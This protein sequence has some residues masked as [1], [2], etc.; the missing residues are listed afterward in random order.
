MRTRL[1]PTLVMVLVTCGLPGPAGR[2]PAAAQTVVRE[3]TPIA[4]DLYRVR[5]AGHYS[6]LLVTPAGI[7]LGD[8]INRDTATWLAAELRSR[9]NQ[10]VRYVIYS[11]DHAD[12]ASGG[13]VFSDTATFV[14]HA[15]TAPAMRAANVPTPVPTQTF[16]ESTVI[17][18]GGARVELT[19]LGPNHGEGMI[20]MR[21]PRERVLFAVDIIPVESLA[22]RDF[23][24]ADL[25]GWLTALRRVEAMDFDVLAPAHGPLGRKAHVR[26]H[27]DYLEDLREQ[28]RSHVQAGRSLADTKARV[29]LSRYKAWAG[30]E[31][32]R[33]LNVEGMYRI[34]SSA[35]R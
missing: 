33:D 26:M 17:E 3:I 14:G 1:L 21:F 11:H 23:P 24:G 16:E 32:S 8:P 7:I 5:S 12:H 20:V 25:D 15:R 10:P 22:F 35:G 34:V 27:R 18:L 30:Y 4:G 13:E 2:Q 9:F 29:D 6:V 28:V 19:Y 31:Q